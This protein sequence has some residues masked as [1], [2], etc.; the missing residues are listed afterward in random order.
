MTKRPNILYIHSHD[1][2]RYVQPYGHAI[3]T[4]NL[5][6][7]AK[8]GVLFRQAFTPNPTCSPSRACLL[9]GQTAHSNGMLGLAHRGF[10]LYDYSHH[11]IHTLKTVGYTSA[12]CGI[13]HIAGGSTPWKTIGYD[14]CPT[15]SGAAEAHTAAIEYLNNTPSQPF[16]LSVGFFNTHR[17]FPVDHPKDDARYVM[18]PS[19]LPD[20]PETRED[21]ARFKQ[22]ARTLD[23]KIGQVL[24]ALDCNG[25]T[26]NTL[27]ICTTDHGIAFPRMKC[28]LQDSGTGIMLIMRGP[29]GF[30]GGKVVD[31]MISNIDLFPSV[32]DYLGINPPARLEGTSFMPIIRGERDRVNDALFFEVNYHAAFEPMRAVRTERYKYIVRYDPR[33]AP[34]LPNCDAGL[35]KTVWV[36]HGWQA[37][38]PATDA[39][40][41]LVMDP[42]ET[43]NLVQDNAHATVLADM[44]QRLA[45]WQHATSDPLVTTGKVPLPSTAICN[46]RDGIDPGDDTLPQGT[47]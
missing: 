28:N 23:D 43:N 38:A 25:L 33:H 45:T 16:F 40:Y 6:K 37:Y 35:S 3:E 26:D 22:S 41:D 18:P 11:I 9:T 1:T 5:Q 29:N 2:G 13:Q 31:S 8:E 20:T 12:L 17:V 44:K 19:P 42:H 39:L 24:A 34:V 32:C 4:P 36:E 10:S 27:V 14:E 15:A 30:S 7:L 21:M 46:P 47:R